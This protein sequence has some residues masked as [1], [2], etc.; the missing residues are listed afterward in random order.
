MD[1]PGGQV[2]R[3]ELFE[4]AFDIADTVAT[5]PYFPY[6]LYPPPGI[7]PGVGLTVDALLLPPGELEWSEARV[8]PCFYYQP[9][10]EAGSG[11]AMAFHPVGDREWRCRFTPERVGTW[12]YKVRAT[13]AAGTFESEVSSFESVSSN[14]RGFIGVSQTDSRFFEFADGT[15]FVTPLVNVEEGNPFNRLADIRANV[16]ELG[17]NGVRFVRWFPTGEGANYFVAPYG[18]TMRVNWH[19]GD[20]WVT[21]NGADAAA[22]KRFSYRPYYYSSQTLVLLPG[23]R[24]RLSFR[25]YVDGEQV[26]RAQVG[27][28]PGGTFDV[29]S[30]GAAYHTARGESCTYRRDG[31]H[32][33]AVI[34]EPS[35]AGPRV[36]EVGLRGLYVSESAPA[37]YNTAQSGTLRVHSIR[38]QRDETGSGE[39]GGNLLTRSDPD[40]YTYVDQQA[41]ARLDEVLRQSE[42]HGVY[43]KLTLFHKNDPLLGRFL[44][45]GTLGAWDINHFYATEGTAVRWYQDAYVRYFV[46]R[47]SYSPALH[48][49]ELANENNFD[50][51]AQDAAYAIA[52]SIHALSP[53]PI[54][55][56]NSFWG[57]WVE[58]FWADPERGELMDYSDK[59]WYANQS[60]AYCDDNGERCDLISNVWD[61][62]AA[63]VRECWRR[64]GEYRAYYDYDK[65]IVRGE[66][67]VAATGTEPQHPDIARD[68]QGTYYHKKLWAH[69]GLLG[70][71]CDGEWYPRL[72]VG[73][74][75][76]AFPNADRDLY[77]M[78]AAYERFLEGERLSRGT[79][80]EIGT[81]LEGEQ[82]I[83]VRDAAGALRA[84]GVRDTAS[85]RTLLWVDNAAH[86]WKAV[87][88]G[89]NPTPASGTLTLRG[90][91]SDKVYE[92]HW[93]DPY[94]ASSGPYEVSMATARADGTLEL[95]VSDLG[96][97]VAIKVIGHRAYRTYLPLALRNSGR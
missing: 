83:T 87:V 33:Y 17:E 66:G 4:L 68:P 81:D 91:H 14:H 20:G 25:A 96:R 30:T 39:W 16:R 86:T 26:L 53:R 52:E 77:G 11:S 5:N 2:P 89:E 61:D 43:H 41:A 56:S 18:D 46:G 31:W 92:V 82:G 75:G 70:D 64:F 72:F 73:N 1:Y 76:G 12:R 51:R 13:D 15:P 79:Y 54:L 69:L 24:Y 38:L 22:G 94:G 95:A 40:T 36:L 67:G 49:L 59:H 57:W 78:F 84:W 74:D 44:P 50:A 35:G 80:V 97:D 21:A 42:H 48:S 37:P 58:S 60:G 71:T 32:D 45:D 88:D 65:P 9:M 47:W 29:C 6:D 23:S 93:W 8:L 34:V 19:F 28:L 55:V 10:E 63:Y 90:F 62:S 7:E 27:N 3:Y 85:G